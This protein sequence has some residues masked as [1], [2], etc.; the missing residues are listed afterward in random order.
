M[1]E[2]KNYCKIDKETNVVVDVLYSD[3]KNIKELELKND[4]YMYKQS[5][6]HSYDDNNNLLPNPRKAPGGVGQLYDP[7]NDGFIPNNNFP[8]WTFNKKTW[9][10]EPP[11][12]VPEDDM[13]CTDTECK[14]KVW[15]E[16]EQQWV[17]LKRE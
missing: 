9:S 17:N 15:N 10:W 7:I 5:F 11:I 16:E 3:E 8:S 13:Q 1:E 14:C 6:E 2:L 4:K 12:E